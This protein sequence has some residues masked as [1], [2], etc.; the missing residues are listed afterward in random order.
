[1]LLP[2][3]LTLLGLEYSR[4][5]LASEKLQPFLL[6]EEDFQEFLQ[7]LLLK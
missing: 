6:I 5:N 7:L 4:V 1:M 2:L 3:D